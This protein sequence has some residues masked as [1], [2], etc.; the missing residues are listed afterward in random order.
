MQFLAKH[1]IPRMRGVSFHGKFE[2]GIPNCNNT[3]RVIR[4]EQVD[5]NMFS[6]QPCLIL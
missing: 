2:M 3:C 4:T 6:P 1:V 5:N